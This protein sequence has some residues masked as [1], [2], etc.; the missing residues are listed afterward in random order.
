MNS[1][2]RKL[3]KGRSILRQVYPVMRSSSRS[4]GC[5]DGGI[6]SKVRVGIFWLYLFVSLKVAPY[7]SLRLRSLEPE[8]LSG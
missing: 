5:E 6:L 2:C 3:G 7:E 8:R 1:S 4:S